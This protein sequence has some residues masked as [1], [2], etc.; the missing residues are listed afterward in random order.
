[1]AIQFLRL[2]THKSY[3]NNIVLE[4]T[5]STISRFNISAMAIQY[6]LEL[7]SYTANISNNYK[8]TT[9]NYK[10]LITKLITYSVVRAVVYTDI[11]NYCGLCESIVY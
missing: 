2:Y 5:I 7:R 6:T 3:Y 1:M 8:L 11:D 9:T 10:L 4:S